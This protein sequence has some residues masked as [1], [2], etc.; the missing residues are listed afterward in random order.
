MRMF[1]VW[2]DRAAYPLL[3]GSMPEHRT[4]ET[5]SM[6]TW[7]SIRVAHEKGLAYDFE[8]SM[9]ERIAKS[10]REYGGTPELYFRIRKVYSPEVVRM[11]AERKIALLE[12]RAGGGAVSA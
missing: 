4:L 9:I 2:D 1:L 7:E 11:E 8:G 6:L 3:G 10:F 5:Y 12:S